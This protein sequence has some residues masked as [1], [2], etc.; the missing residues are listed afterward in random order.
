MKVLVLNGPNLDRLG[1]RQPDIY[2]SATL[3]EIMAAVQQRGRE[4]DVA[5]DW[6]QSNDEGVLVSRIGA[7]PGVYDGIILNP[8]AYTHT[9]I[10]LRDALQAADIPCVEVH[11]SNIHARE[12]FRHHS[13]TAPA[14]IGQILGFGPLGYVLALEALADHL[15]RRP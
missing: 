15:R 14:C 1:T 7:A 6:F 10:A 13:L 9:S 11:L 5:V 12:S 4:M 3:P 2:G 8:A